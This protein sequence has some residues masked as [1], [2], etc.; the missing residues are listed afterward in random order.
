VL[1]R[2]ATLTEIDF[3]PPARAAFFVPGF[4]PRRRNPA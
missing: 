4:T 2:A 3:E 1:Q